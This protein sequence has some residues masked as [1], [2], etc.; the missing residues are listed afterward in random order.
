[1]QEVR[2]GGST[3]SGR[4]AEGGRKSSDTGL[5][6]NIKEVQANQGWR[7]GFPSVCV[8]PLGVPFIAD[9]CGPCSGPRN[10]AAVIGSHAPTTR[11]AKTPTSYRPPMSR[12][13]GMASY[14]E[15]DAIDCEECDAGAVCG[16]CLVLVLKDECP[17]NVDDFQHMMDANGLLVRTRCQDVF[18]GEVCE[19]SGECGTSDHADNCL[20]DDIYRHVECYGDLFLFDSQSDPPLSPPP[21][22]PPTPPS[23]PPPSPQKAAPESLGRAP[24]LT[25]TSAI[26]PA[27]APSAADNFGLVVGCVAGAVVLVGLCFARKRLLHAW[28]VQRQSGPATKL[29]SGGALS[30]GLAQAW[31]GRG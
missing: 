10:G 25:T 9:P 4:R 14:D 27:A 11:S 17:K 29:I 21:T 2:K 6:S 23:T 20:T 19:G 5:Q 13:L 1:M 16:M 8:Y 15:Q 24:V 28:S 3:S 22:P 30:A 31:L 12:R 18:R 7:S 26:S